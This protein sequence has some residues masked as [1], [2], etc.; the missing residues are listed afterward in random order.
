MNDEISNSSDTNVSITNNK[1]SSTSY[2]TKSKSSINTDIQYPDKVAI[3]T[4]Q[5]YQYAT[6][7]F[8]DGLAY[9]Q[10][11]INTDALKFQDGRLFFE[12]PSGIM[13]KVSEVELITNFKTQE[14]LT[15]FTGLPFLRV[16]Y[17][18][19]L[20]K[21]SEV[22]KKKQPLPKIISLY[23]PELA[24]YLGYRRSKLNQDTIAAIVARTASFNHVIGVLHVTRNDKPDKSY[25][26]IFLFCEY[27]AITNTVELYSPYVYKVID[28]IYKEAIKYDSKQ[29]PKL[30]QSGEPILL[31][32]HSFLIKPTISKEKNLA[33][34][35]NVI[36]IV[37]VIEQAGN[38]TA[39]I[40]ASTLIERN[41]M[42]EYRLNEAESKN[43]SHILKRVFKRTWE[44]LRDET[45]LT[46]VYKNIQL[47]DPNNPA[48]VPTQKTLDM[49]FKFPH[50]GKIKK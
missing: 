45:T 31:P 35:E 34:I 28:T 39:N 37:Q 46:E 21:Y 6:T 3:T 11:G 44:L 17:S 8:Q 47:P 49:V 15:D 1:S 43:K 24:D 9:L 50:E 33:A 25:Y 30:N 2:R 18:I 12:D 19:I 40:K 27:D 20:R 16:Y 29:R 14:P 13:K 48:E 32:S 42:L 22:I 10:A 26:P 23:M 4:Y 36:L 7:F 38:Y 41:P 5:P